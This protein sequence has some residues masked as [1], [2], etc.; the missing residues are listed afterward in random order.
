[1][2]AFGALIIVLGLILFAGAVFVYWIFD[3]LKKSSNKQGRKELRSEATRITKTIAT[4]K[5]FHKGL[6]EEFKPTII[7]FAV[8]GFALLLGALGIGD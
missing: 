6:K 7:L 1:M 4:D 3:V 2:R 5:D 8:I